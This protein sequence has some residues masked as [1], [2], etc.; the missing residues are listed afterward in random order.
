MAQLVPSSFVSSGLDAPEA[1]PEDYGYENEPYAAQTMF[2]AYRSGMDVG[3]ADLGGAEDVIDGAPKLD[4]NGVIDAAAG[5]ATGLIG[6]GFS[7]GQANKGRQHESLMAD[8]NMDLMEQQLQ[9]AALQ[10]SPEEEEEGSVLPWVIGGTLAVAVLGGGGFLYWKSQQN[11][12][13]V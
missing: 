4:A 12:A 3:S 11:K 10:S 8:K 1:D 6:I 2:H 7:V 5:L 9:L 13:A